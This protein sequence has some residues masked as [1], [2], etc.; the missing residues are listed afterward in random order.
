MIKLSDKDIK[1]IK[2][3][4]RP[5]IVIPLMILTLA[6]LF[7]LIYLS[8]SNNSISQIIILIINSGII[9]FCVFLSF[10]INWNYNKDLKAGTK[11]IEIERVN[12]KEERTIYEAGSGTLYLPI[13]GYLFPKLWGQPMKPIQK[14]HLIINHCRYDIEKEMYDNIKEGDLVEMYYS[15]YSEILLGI[16]LHRNK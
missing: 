16:E 7:N 13:L 5:G 3:E 11:K 12:K 6:G 15:Q 1:I 9:T 10:L 14:L 2:Y 8:N 4:R